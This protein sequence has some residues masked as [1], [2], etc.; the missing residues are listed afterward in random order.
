ME[1]VKNCELVKASIV[2]DTRCEMKWYDS[3][4][5][6][7]LTVK[8]NKQ[9]WDKQSS[10]FVDDPEKAAQ[11]E[12]WAQ[13]YIGCSFDE[14]P[15]TLGIVHDVYVYDRFNSLWEVEEVKRPKKFTEAIKKIIRTRIENVYIDNV[16]IH[17]EYLY[18]GD[19]YES[20]Y[21]TS[22][23]IDKLRK[24]V[25]DPDKEAKA[26]KRF[27]DTFGVEPEEAGTLIG[28]EIQVQVKKAFS[29]YYG[30]I[31]PIV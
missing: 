16:G 18:E 24:F 23:W 10:T 11:C 28:T 3:E 6:R 9:S 27:A 15:E 25:P 8:F 17:V 12:A 21:G 30:D 7:L 5:D 31:L 14:I 26:R 13:E 22:E 4:G 20:K 29:S 2:N 1:I 19:L